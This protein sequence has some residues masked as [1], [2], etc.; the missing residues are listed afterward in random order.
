M[1]W[2]MAAALARCSARSLHIISSERAWRACDDIMAVREDLR[3]LLAACRSAAFQAD[4]AVASDH[5]RT[6]GAA[7]FFAAIAFLRRAY[8]ST[9]MI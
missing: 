5:A 3:C 8:Q 9:K 6:C 2:F 7:I 4:G 1:G